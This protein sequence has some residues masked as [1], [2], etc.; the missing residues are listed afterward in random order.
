MRTINVNYFGF[1][2][3]KS[4]GVHLSSGHKSRSLLD[5]GSGSTLKMQVNDFLMFLSHIVFPRGLSSYLI[6]TSGDILPALGYL[7]YQS[8]EKNI[9]LRDRDRPWNDPQ[10]SVFWV[11]VPRCSR[12]GYGTT[13]SLWVQKKIVTLWQGTQ[14]TRLSPT[15]FLREFF[16][17][18]PFDFF[19]N[20][21]NILLSYFWVNCVPWLS[22]PGIF[23]CFSRNCC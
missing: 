8:A 4:V 21:G 19:R 22:V 9:S 18:S 13:P 3:V 11:A 2:S 17:H 14:D 16:G 15:E 7:D 23:R 10:W 12:N 6:S 20:L 5:W 1:C